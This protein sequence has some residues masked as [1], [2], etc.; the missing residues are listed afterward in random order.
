MAEKLGL[1]DSGILSSQVDVYFT[2][3]VKEL[4]EAL[5]SIMTTCSSDFTN[6]FRDLAKVSKNLKMTEED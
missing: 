1:I 3:E 4:L 6:T 2:E 5:W